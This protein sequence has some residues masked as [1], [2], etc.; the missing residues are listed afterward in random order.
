M[1]NYKHLTYTQ[2]LQ[3]EAYLNSGVHKKVIAEK[4]G[5]ALSTVYYEIKKGQYERLDYK[6]Y[7][8][9]TA[10]SAD[11]A[12]QRYEASMTAKGVPLKIGNDYAFAEFVE[13]N[14]LAGMSPSA[15]LATARNNG[16]NFKT[17]VCVN[18]LYSYIKKGVLGVSM[19]DCP[20]GNKLHRHRASTKPKRAPRGT[21]IEKRPEAIAERLTFGHWEMDCVCGPTRQVLL[22]LTERKTRYEVILPMRNQTAESVVR[23]LDGLERRYGSEFGKIFKTIT[24]DNGSEFSDF[25]GM[26]RS[27]NGGKRTDVYYCH[28]YSFFERGSNERMNREI[29]RKIPKGSDLSQYSEAYV[30]DV[31][32]W[33]NNYPRK[34]LAWKTSE[35][36]FNE[37]VLL[38]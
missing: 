21:S 14:I 27:I 5:V 1:Q 7:E 20:Y 2:R 10:Y 18:T 31:E 24:V 37:Q 9:V 11:V 12:Q 34:I 15:I 23:C 19:A 35:Q 13:S 30:K 36:L 17:D 28:P 6:T 8:M 25:D 29:R 16:L 22:V 3:L 4:L 26:Q 32:T 38:L 33:V